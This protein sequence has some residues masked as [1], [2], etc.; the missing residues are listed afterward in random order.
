MRLCSTSNACVRMQIPVFTVVDDLNATWARLKGGS[1]GDVQAPAIQVSSVKVRKQPL[2][3]EQK[4]YQSYALLLGK[5][6]QGVCREARAGFQ[7]RQRPFRSHCMHPPILLL[8]IEVHVITRSVRREAMYFCAPRP[9][10]CVCK[11]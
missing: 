10:V 8:V 5:R 4:K 3:V 1:G 9:A 7:M 11:R 2:T 6:V